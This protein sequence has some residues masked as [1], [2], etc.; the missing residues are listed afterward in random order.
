M[1]MKEPP[2]GALA[3]RSVADLMHT[4]V[5]SIRPDAT[6]RAL[7]N[8]LWRNDVSGVPV[9][10]P[11]GKVL[12]VASATDILWL[13]DRMVP[14]NGL[15]GADLLSWDGWDRHTVAEIM[16]ADVFAVSPTDSIDD[17]RRFF[18][19][20]GVHRALVLEDDELVGVVSLSDLLAA[21]ARAALAGLH[22]SGR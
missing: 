1:T 17:L 14:L 13:S 2:H 15:R 12:G 22:L 11:G 4:D 5:V 9:V 19:R 6:I 20:T 8:L 21:I 7:A 16:T 3:L 18:T 10:A